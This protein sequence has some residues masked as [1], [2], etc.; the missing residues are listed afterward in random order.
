M[1][2]QAMQAEMLSLKRAQLWFVEQVQVLLV[3]Q[4]QLWFVEQV[5]LQCQ[6][7]FDVHQPSDWDRKSRVS[8]CKDHCFHLVREFSVRLLVR[9]QNACAVQ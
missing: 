7:V 5:E 2:L 6:V 3:E 9:Q 4:A 1:Q 8:H